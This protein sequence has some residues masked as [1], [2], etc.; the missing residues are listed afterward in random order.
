MSVK[1][2]YTNVEKITDNFQSI[3]L[4]FA[5]LTIAYGF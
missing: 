2:C 1:E 5:R 3:A 4:L